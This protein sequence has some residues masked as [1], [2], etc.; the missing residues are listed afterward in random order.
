MRT[1][2]RHA[3]ALFLVAFFCKLALEAQESDGRSDVPKSLLLD[4]LK[5]HQAIPA[6]RF[7]SR[8]IFAAIRKD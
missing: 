5:P 1:I 3:I 2:L 6:G 7:D 8:R 4:S